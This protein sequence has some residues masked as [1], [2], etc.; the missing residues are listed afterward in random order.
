[1]TA[2]TPPT[3]RP[4]PSAR[5]R[6]LLVAGL[7]VVALATVAWMV[8]RSPLLDVDRVLVRGNQHSTVDEVMEA[9]EL[10]R[11]E[12]LVWLDLERARAGIEALPWVR[13]ARVERA[14]PDAVRVTLEERRAVA[15]ADAGDGRALVVDPSGRV[16]AIEAQPPSGLPQLL[17]VLPAVAV[18]GS[19]APS[20]GARVA[21]ALE[22]IVQASTRGIATAP[23]GR[24]T[25]QTAS[26]Q[27]IRLGRPTHLDD[28]VR[29]AVAVLGAPQAAGKVYVDVSAPANPVAG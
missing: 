29:A 1:V 13:A 9:G 12:P 10:S 7:V 18:G 4:V 20:T 15:W 26:G 2:P 28:K 14:W 23:D 21:G 5:R 19:I 8:S 16:L 17:D 24:V 27:E 6:R 11:G 25:L 3:A 22:G